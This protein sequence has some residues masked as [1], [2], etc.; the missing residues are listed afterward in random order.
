MTET[1]TSSSARRPA[2]V[3]PTAALS[4]DERRL[5]LFAALVLGTQLIGLGFI[6]A[7]F[8][9]SHPPMDATPVEA[10][11]GFRDARTMIGIATYLAVLPL[12]F[13]LPL[14]G[15]LSSVLRRAGGGPMVPTTLGAGLAVFLIPAIGA[16]V[17]SVTPAIG[18]EDTSVSA[19]AVIKALDGVM[20][21][22]VALAGFPSSVMLVCVA[23][24]LARAGL[25]GRIMRGTAYGIAV[26]GLVGTG[27][28][29]VPAMFPIASLS[30]LFFNLWL[31]AVALSL[32]GGRAQARLLELT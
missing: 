22:S 3:D 15:G 6:F 9:T 31:T 12:L 4:R 29:L 5:L 18:L 14:L 21:L 7:F 20:P 1:R 17:S 32:R 25:A 8:A 2:A 13:A 19:G 16:I 30:M 26:L 24:V 11:I 28:L 10:A 27:T 23:L